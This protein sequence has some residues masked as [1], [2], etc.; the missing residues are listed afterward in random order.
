MI[1]ELDVLRQSVHSRK[2]SQYQAFR[3][4][5][6]EDLLPRIEYSLSVL[7][8]IATEAIQHYDQERIKYNAEVEQPRERNHLVPYV[9]QKEVKDR[10]YLRFV[11]ARLRT[12][13]HRA[14]CGDYGMPGIQEI[15]SGR[16]GDYSEKKLNSMLS[17]S[18]KAALPLL[19]NTEHFLRYCRREY[20][21]FSR[22]RR[23]INQNS[24][25]RFQSLLGKEHRNQMTDDEELELSGMW[26]QL[27][28]GTH[29]FEPL[30]LTAKRSLINPKN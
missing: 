18:N 13:S 8:E 17:I 3:S 14:M 30:G 23:L 21:Y 20:D 19:I 25:G 2:F 6:D 16:N 10:T 9:R 7:V 26:A 28:T 5:T 1:N 27:I 15:T 29:E 12:Q 11:W 4:R 22:L 24:L